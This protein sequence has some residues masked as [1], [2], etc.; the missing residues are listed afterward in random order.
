MSNL[1]EIIITGKDLSKKAF[2]EAKHSGSSFGSA[3]SKIGLGVAV[4]AAGIAAESVKMAAEFQSATTRLATSAGEQVSNLKMV[5]S[6]MLDMAGQVGMSA[7]ELAKG[8]YTVESAGEHGADGLMVLKAAAQGAKDENADL[9]T[10]ANAV[11]D[12]LTDYHLKASSAAD[13]TSKLVESVSFGK[14]TFE[15]FSKAMANVLPLAGSL[16][17]SLADVSGVLAEM[18]AHGMTAQR[19]SQ[20]EAQAMRSLIAP[21]GTMVKEF[22]LLGITS[23]EVMQHMGK[24][25]LSGTMEW[26]SQVAQKG[27]KSVGQNYTEALKKLMGTAPGLAVALMTTGENAT[28]TA[29]AI[30]GIGRA[31]ADAHG[32]VKG[33]AEV[34]HTLTQQLA[35]LNAGFDSMMIRLGTVLIPVVTSF[36]ELLQS[37]GTP[38]LDRFVQTISRVASGFGAAKRSADDVKGSVLAAMGAFVNPRA[39]LVGGERVISQKQAAVAVLPG[40]ERPIL[41]GA[42]AAIN[43]AVQDMA[44]PTGLQK[45]GI[46]LS[47]V[48]DDLRKFV[49]EAVKAGQ[50]LFQALQPTLALLGATGL[51]TLQAVASIL[52]NVLG[53][54]LVAVTGFMNDHKSAVTALV[55]VALI[56]LGIRLAALAVIKPVTAI[57]SL[58]VDIVKF[59]FVQAKAIGTAVSSGWDTARGVWGG[60]RFAAITVGQL[61]S[62]GWARVASGATAAGRGIASLA[63]TSWAGLTGGISA[64]GRGLKFAGDAALDFSK[65][66]LLAT[67]AALKQAA[68]FVWEKITMAASVIAE[69]AVTAGQWLLNIALDANPIGAVILAIGL[70]V[71][72]L[73]ELYRRSE[74]VREQFATAWS[75]NEMVAGIAAKLIVQSMK[76]LADAAMTALGVIVDGA[77]SAFGW[78]PGVGSKLKEAQA[79][80]DGFRKTA[81]DGFNS[82]I[83]KADAFT[84]SAAKATVERRLQVQIGGW[85]DNLNKAK[86]QLKSVPASKRAALL[87]DIA[88]LV[89]KIA[90]AQKTIDNLQG[91]TVVIKFK[92]VNEGT[93]GSNGY[94]STTG[95]SYA[96]GGIVSRAATGGVRGL[97]WVGEQGP[98]LVRLPTGS[99]VYPAGQ[100]RGMAAAAG[101]GGAALQIEWVG[102]QNA[103]DEFMRWLRRNIRITGGTGDGSVQRAL[104][105]T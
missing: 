96:H 85:T 23:Q 45:I 60:M 5:G 39:Q 79:A 8:M 100:S 65:K 95:F 98:E 35:Q 82:M 104:G 51:V 49:T 54:A 91:K 33:F 78:I 72:G 89:S 21:S 86:D 63:S 22:K 44:P 90:Q 26:L 30:K 71:T 105:Y 41:P 99:M 17:L 20:N 27:A 56:P 42:A 93:L 11:T 57:A 77:A 94:T 18:T 4:V 66:A 80:F 73:Y 32:D 37:R 36:V 53:P 84:Q 19:A 76:W 83:S 97:T 59:P 16:H 2:E 6:G 68:A 34:Q 1:V 38:V 40:G 58:A 50:Q 3:M 103:G 31:T 52:A 67:A 47:G 81:D 70:L 101:G 24:V 88:D 43:K 13:V 28:A 64:V 74:W 12:V 7:T 14:T 29:N 69:A 61:A 75:A 102:P 10:V 55:T 15:S 92:G 25:G 48:A 87:A 9:G 46:A 62:A